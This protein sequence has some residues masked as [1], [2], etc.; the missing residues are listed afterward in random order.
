MTKEIV[1]IPPALSNTEQLEAHLE[2]LVSIGILGK[3][4]DPFSGQQRYI[5]LGVSLDD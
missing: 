5:S 4:E 2:K 3:F 1:Q